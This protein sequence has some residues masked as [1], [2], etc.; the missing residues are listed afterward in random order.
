[1]STATSASADEAV[2]SLWKQL[3]R[4][5]T[6]ARGI[7]TPVFVFGG[8]ESALADLHNRLRDIA[9]LES[10]PFLECAPT[11][12]PD[13][14]VVR[15]LLGGAPIA[16][17]LVWIDLRVAA[18]AHRTVVLSLMARLNER[19]AELEQRP[20]VVLFVLPQAWEPDVAAAAPDLW[21][22][23]QASVAIPFGS[24][25]A[26]A[27]GPVG[28]RAA[29]SASSGPPTRPP[30]V[31]PAIE[32]WY[33]QREA[34]SKV[35]SLW[36]GFLAVDA[37]LKAGLD[38][39]ANDIAADTLALAETGVRS[40]PDDREALRDLSVSLNKVGDAASARGDIAAAQAAYARSLET[41]ERLI[42]VHGENRE[43]L[44]DLSISL[45]NVGDAASARGDIAASQA[46]YARCLETLERLIAE[47][48]E[49]REALG[50]LASAHLHVAAL[51]GL[52]DADVDGA[53]HRQQAR[54]LLTRLS[55]AFP[56][57]AVYR[58]QLAQMDQQEI[59]EHE[60]A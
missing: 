47:Y 12:A 18:T 5:F 41:R 2:S 6:L 3:R 9:Q 43:A 4:K 58:D 25:G 7:L 8:R 39:E 34:G 16:W 28:V 14:V 31:E 30:I 33:R 13:T 10:W 49:N 22:L 27:T 54:T 46:A 21:H 17:R 52:G 38:H 59:G 40:R 11:D 56:D 50:D 1:M 55:M 24:P 60:Q 19:R 20:A 26:S 36:D 35:A 57:I 15:L 44:R 53:S 23:R 42:A 29:A 37:A 48:G 32:R 51:A 45:N